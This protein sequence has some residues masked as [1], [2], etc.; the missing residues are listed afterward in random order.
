MDMG[1]NRE[2]DSKAT[3][4]APR[5]LLQFAVRDAVGTPRPSGLTTEPSLKRLRSVVSTSTED[6]TP[7]IRPV[8]RIPNTMAV[9]IKAVADAAKD[10]K[11]VKSSGNVFDRITHTVDHIT[12]S[13]EA[14]IEDV[15]DDGKFGQIPEETHPTFLLRS[16]MNMSESDAD[17]EGFDDVNVNRGVMDASQ[18]G[19][20]NPIKGDDSLMVQYSVAADNANEVAHKPW[21]DEDHQSAAIASSTTSSKMVN[22][23]V[24]VNSWKPHHYQEQKEALDMD[25]RKFVQ[26]SEVGADKS[27]LRLMKENSSPVTVDNGK[28]VP[29]A[30]TQ[31]EPQKTLQSIPGLY[32]TGRP[33]EDAD[34]RTI[35]VSNVHF[36]ATKDSLSRH[37]NKFGDVL[38]VV[39][40]TDAATGQP[41]GSAY[42]EF[43][44]KE[45]AEHA[46]SLDGTSFMSR[47]LKFLEISLQTLGETGSE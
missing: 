47:I 43:M 3:I 16:N 12:E 35:F 1:M 15:E 32:S 18:T 8:A 22:V 14:S 19:M 44:R 5:R 21:K 26:D 25:R 29:E 31:R 9:A 37:F 11:R 2:V 7:R 39:I 6:H 4:G 30:D 10:V 17:N 33:T 24:N 27:G 46:L 23:S 36:A 13:R 42:V 28:A 20:S 34:S 38:K 41:K 40:V 45:A